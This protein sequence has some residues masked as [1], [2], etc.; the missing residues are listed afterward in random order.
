MKWMDVRLKAAQYL[1]SDY[2]AF[3]RRQFVFGYMGYGASARKLSD[4]PLVDAIAWECARHLIAGTP[5]IWPGLAD[6]IGSLHPARTRRKLGRSGN[7]SGSP[8]G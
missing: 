4:T 8:C 6:S 7:A 3:F 1:G 5:T 2:C